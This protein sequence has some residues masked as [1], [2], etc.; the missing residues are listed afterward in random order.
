MKR[1]LIILSIVLIPLSGTAGK[2]VP[3][4]RLLTAL[5]EFRST[6]GVE[7]VQLGTLATSA[8]RAVAS[9]SSAGDE[10]ARQA[11]ALMKGVRRVTVFDYEDCDAAVKEKIGRRLNRIL[12]DSEI[13][14]EAKDGEDVMKLYGVT[15]SK[16]ENVRDFVLYTPGDCAL[17]CIFGKISM[18]AVEKII[19]DND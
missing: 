11:L 4:N 14:F 18:A 12:G 1:L 8:L 7:L 15:D 3:R 16:G 9:L 2:S 10:D 5:S 19:R 13:L 17:I 6:E